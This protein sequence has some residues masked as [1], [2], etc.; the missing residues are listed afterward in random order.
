M[1]IQ[2][3][4]WECGSCDLDDEDV[5]NRKKLS[6]DIQSGLKSCR[7]IMEY[8]FVNHTLELLVCEESFL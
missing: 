2:H 4:R 5:L 8:R 1:R 6:F 3:G 7:P